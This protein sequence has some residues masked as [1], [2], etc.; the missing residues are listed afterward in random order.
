[1]AKE[2]GMNTIDT[3]TVN[4]NGLA[5]DTLIGVITSILG[6]FFTSYQMKPYLKQVIVL[7]ISILLAA[8]R[9]FLTGDFQATNLAASIVTVVGS[10]WV[11]YQTITEKLAKQ[12]QTVGPIKDSATPA[13]I[14]ANITQGELK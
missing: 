9:C 3:P 6:G 10:A 14:P 8:G 1:M 11:A 4:L 2:N 5:L 13:E 12:L 7:A